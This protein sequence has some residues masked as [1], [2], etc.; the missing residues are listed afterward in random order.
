[1]LTFALVVV[2]AAYAQVHV[3]R[4]IANISYYDNVVWLQLRFLTVLISENFN[5]ARRG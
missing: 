4:V 5:N 3:I 1:M 2:V